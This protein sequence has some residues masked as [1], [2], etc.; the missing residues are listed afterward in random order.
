MDS[1]LLERELERVRPGVLAIIRASV[2]DRALAED[3]CGEA[4]R[5]TMERLARQPLDDPQKLEA[6]V[7][8][9]ARNLAIAERRKAARQRTMTGE[10]ESLEQHVDELADVAVEAQRRSRAQAIRSVLD[11]L[12]TP[13]DRELLVRFYLEDEDR[14]TICQDLGLTTEHFNRVIFRARERF[15]VLLER[16]YAARDL[17]GLFLG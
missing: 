2:R 1:T 5:I 4:I 8:Q 11:E 12:P 6:Y 15:R 13:R 3:L 10:Q 14:E 17:L 16:R 9:T 7:A